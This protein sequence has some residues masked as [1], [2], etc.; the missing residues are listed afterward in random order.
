LEGNLDIGVLGDEFDVFVKHPENASGHTFETFINWIF[1]VS[2]LL[3]LV[4][5]VFKNN[6]DEC[7]Q[8]NKE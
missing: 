7:D 5:D 4:N 1:F 6:S 8:S 3:I 2:D